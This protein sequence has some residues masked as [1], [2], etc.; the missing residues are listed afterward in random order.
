MADPV[1]RPADAMD[2]RSHAL[3]LGAAFEAKRKKQHAK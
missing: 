1:P 3:A 2:A